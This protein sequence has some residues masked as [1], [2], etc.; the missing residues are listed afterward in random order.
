MVE[1]AERLWNLLENQEIQGLITDIGF[2]KIC[3]FVKKLG[4]LEAV[5]QITSIIESMV[6]VQTVDRD[7]IEEA[8]SF[9]LLDFESAVEIV[10]ADAW[11]VGAIV[12][13]N[14]QSFSEAELP[15]LSLSQLLQRQTLENQLLESKLE[16]LGDN[17]NTSLVLLNDE[18]EISNKNI[19]PRKLTKRLLNLGILG[20]ILGIITS[21]F[22]T[23]LNFMLISDLFRKDFLSASVFYKDPLGLKEKNNSDIYDDLKVFNIDVSMN[24]ADKNFNMIL[25]NDIYQIA[26]LYDGLE[27]RELDDII[28]SSNNTFSVIALASAKAVPENSSIISL[29]FISLLGLAGLYKRKKNQVKNNK[30]NLQKSEIIPPISNLNFVIDDFKTNETETLSK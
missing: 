9:D 7:L 8:R 26:T 6:K 1:D 3:I 22:G 24:N 25:D 20:I 28:A 17:I 30:N 15:I 12:T 11:N 2:K 10:C 13:Q 5:E 21:S 29:G 4:G 23:S 18:V 19:A 16:S 14:I 27:N